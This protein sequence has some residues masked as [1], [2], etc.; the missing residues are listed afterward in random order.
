MM[1]GPLNALKQRITH[2]LTK[3]HPSSKGQ[4]CDFNT[5]MH[6]IKPGDVLLIDG[7][8][9]ISKIIQYITQSPWSHAV[10]Y[11]GRAMDFDDPDTFK[12]IEQHTDIS[13]NPPLIIESQLG[14]GT[15]LSP[16]TKYKDEHLRICRPKGLTYEDAQAVI[17]FT[18]NRI[19][20][21]YNVRQVFDLARFFLPWRLLPRRLGSSLFYPKGKKQKDICSTLIAEAFAS[22]KFPILPEI[23]QGKDHRISII[24]HNPNIF[25]PSDFDY[26]PYFEIIKYPMINIAQPP[27]YR[28]LPW[29]EEGIVSDGEGKYSTLKKKDGSS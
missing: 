3:N 14:E 29:S 24:R 20:K 12:Q 5:L 26:S 1:G 11:I 28:N 21:P 23:K 18:L 27:A 19:G 7:S 6:E 10:L 25:T 13:H 15:M 2:W 17:R 9:H 22:V 16:L 4:L 8:T